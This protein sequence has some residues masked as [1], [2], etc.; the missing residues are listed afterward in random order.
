MRVKRPTP[1]ITLLTDPFLQRPHPDVTEVAWF[2]EFAGDTHHVIVGKPVA[3]M[4]AEQ[5]HR[6]IAGESAPGVRVV[7]AHT[8]T[9]SRVA[10]DAESRLPADRR[11]AQGIVARVVHRHHALIDV[12]AGVRTP[13]RVAS[14]TGAAIAVSDTFTVRGPLRPGEPAVIMLTSDHQLT[15]NTAAN[16]HFAAAT[17]TSHLGAIDAVFAAGDLVNVPDRASEWFDDDSGA[18]FFPTMQARGARAGTD[19]RVYRGGQILQHAPIYPAIGNHDVQGR[20]AGHTALAASFSNTIP[21]AVAEAEYHRDAAAINPGDD[22]G[23]K[24]SWIEDNSFSTT[25]FQEI[26]SLPG[27]GPYYATTVGDVRLIVLFATRAW[28]GEGAD[29]DPAM[30]TATTRY[31]DCRTSVDDPLERGHGAFLFEDLGVGSQQY[32]WLREELGSP[33]FRAARYTVVM[34]HEGPHSLGE[35]ATPPFAHPLCTEDRDARGTLVGWRYDYPA[36]E[37]ILLHEVAPLLDAAGVD[38]VLNGHNHLWNR[39]VSPTGVNYLEGSNTGNSFGAFDPA[40]G[41]QRR[42]PPAPWNPENYCAQG[43]PGGLRPMIPTTA[44]VTDTQ[45]R[46]LP[47]IADD[48]VVVF[49]ALD[50]G[51]GTVTSWYVDMADPRGLAVMFDVL[52]L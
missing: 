11:P 8:T 9:L 17:I 19:G 40:S 12:P 24:A 34:L 23:V 27:G 36:T 39:F 48:N 18:G 35:N 3:A 31:Q 52:Q 30:R 14:V 46:P 5:V 28:R 22:P 15:V 42:V 32:D 20:R 37:D 45:G 16:L 43:D 4:S 44:P 6:L 38:L 10:E 50:T 13:Y 1:P 41:K 49:Q 21:R 25:T 2:S 51:A 29:P 26:F 47:F 7:S 33:A